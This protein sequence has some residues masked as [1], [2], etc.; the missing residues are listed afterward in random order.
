MQGKLWL[1]WLKHGIL[2]LVQ[3][4][5][6]NHLHIDLIPSPN[7]YIVTILMFPLQIS[8]VIGI[9][10][11]FSLGLFQ[12]IFTQSLGYHAFSATTL[13]YLRHYWL[14]FLLGRTTIEK[15]K[16]FDLNRSSPAWI[17]SYFIP[18]VILYQFLWFFMSNGM[19][20]KDFGA[21]LFNNFLAIIL[22]LFLCFSAYVLFF[23][24]KKR[25]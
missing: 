13:M 11:A 12:D 17:L 6:I 5:F 3:I 23:M 1:L 16:D 18:L 22:S 25:R 10:V 14:M 21:K 15:D 20:L 8:R 2:F 19:N 4:L 9:F 24:E 7:L